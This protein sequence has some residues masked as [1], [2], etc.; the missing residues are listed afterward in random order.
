MSEIKQCLTRSSIPCRYLQSQWGPITEQVGRLLIDRKPIVNK[1]K[2]KMTHDT[3]GNKLHLGIRQ[4]FADAVLGSDAKRLKS[5]LTIGEGFL[6]S[7]L[8]VLRQPALGDE[9]VM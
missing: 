5:F 1:V 8:V 3:S 2:I 4:A 9:A 6:G 7:L